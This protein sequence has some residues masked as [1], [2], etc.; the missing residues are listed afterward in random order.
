M[1]WGTV[2]NWVVIVF[3]SIPPLRP[4][5][6]RIKHRLR[7]TTSPPIQY[8]EQSSSNRPRKLLPWTSD[9]ADPKS[10]QSDMVSVVDS[11]P[12]IHF[13]PR[14]SISHA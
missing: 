4:L 13:H 9:T 5:W 8:S 1:I 10:L 11:E 14:T 6:L 7:P 12:A 3:A 2:E